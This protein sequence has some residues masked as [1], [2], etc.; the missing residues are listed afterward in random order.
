MAN[1]Q[2]L[3][4]VTYKG[5]M[6]G[7]KE[8]VLDFDSAPEA[9][10][11]Y[12]LNAGVTYL[13]ANRAASTLTGWIK[14]EII[15]DSDRKPADVPASE[16]KSWRE[17]NPDQ[18]AAW[19]EEIV[20]DTMNDFLAGT[21]G[22][23]E[24]AAPK[25]DVDPVG[26]EMRRLAKE[27]VTKILEANGHKFPTRSKDPAT[28]K[29]VAEKFVTGDGAFTGAELIERQIARNGDALKKQAE[30]IVKMRGKAAGEGA[31]LS[32]L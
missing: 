26:A 15:G 21:I 16:V 12:A 31:D 7:G 3:G 6:T 32:A 24:P 17:A 8:I 29:M 23:R 14:S 22:V 28:G 19:Q 11:K 30:Q 9:S 1:L 5:A 13:F 4:T 2:S 25:E 18:L 27:A 10:V 20:A